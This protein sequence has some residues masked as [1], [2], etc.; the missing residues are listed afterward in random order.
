MQK[1]IQEKID[2]INYFRTKLYKKP[3]SNSP[4]VQAAKYYSEGYY[5]FAYQQIMRTEDRNKRRI[6]S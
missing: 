1:T 3:T 4:I 5:K 6:F 2:L